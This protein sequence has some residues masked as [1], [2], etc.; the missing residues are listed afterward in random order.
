MSTNESD[1][2]EIIA[3]TF[4]SPELYQKLLTEYYNGLCEEDL[5]TASIDCKI[6]QSIYQTKFSNL[7]QILD[8]K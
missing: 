1:D 3:S 6:A 7:S 2:F 8:K 4:D 5:K